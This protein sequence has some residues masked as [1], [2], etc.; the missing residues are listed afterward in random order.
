MDTVSNGVIIPVIKPCSI[1]VSVSTSI[2]YLRFTYSQLTAFS[3][4][5]LLINKYSNFI[6]ISTNPYLYIAIIS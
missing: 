6:V 3:S 4:L 2:A 1:V 5:L